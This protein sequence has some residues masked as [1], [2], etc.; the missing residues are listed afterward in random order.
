M[1]NQP[2]H[3]E[4]WMNDLHF[5]NEDPLYSLHMESKLLAVVIT[6]LELQWFN[7][8]GVY[9]PTQS[10]PIRVGAPGCRQDVVLLTRFT[11]FRDSGWCKFLGCSILLQHLSMTFF[12]FVN[13]SSLLNVSHEALCDL[14]FD[15]FLGSYLSCDILHLLCTGPLT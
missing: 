1:R 15:D 13:R 7:R 4:C 6:H 9:F 3:F 8:M 2:L 5:N 10:N 12:T 14:V 11:L